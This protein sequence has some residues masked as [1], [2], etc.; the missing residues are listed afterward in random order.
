MQSRLS[1]AAG[2]PVVA[3]SNATA[4]GD[5]A[6]ALVELD[7]HEDTGHSREQTETI[8]KCL[9]ED[10]QDGELKEKRKVHFRDD[11]LTSEFDDSNLWA[12]GK[13]LL[14]LD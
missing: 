5:L 9:E 11:N 6:N 3:M 8:E 1:A 12:R 13:L 14:S 10:D 2:T 7:K 4:T